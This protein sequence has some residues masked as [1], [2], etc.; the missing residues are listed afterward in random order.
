MAKIINILDIEPTKVSKDLQGKY[1]LIYGAAKA[2]KTTFATKMPKN[3]L[4]AFEQGYNALAGVKAVDI[5]KWA[6]FKLVLRQL[7][8]PEAQKMYSTITIDTAGIAYTM[9]EEYICAQQGVSSIGDIPYGGGYGLVEK[10]FQNCLRQI[11]Q[12]G[13][14]LIIISHAIPRV[15][16]KSDGSEIEIVSPDIPKRGYKVINQLVDIIGYIDVQWDEDGTSS[17]YLYTRKTP[18]IM[19][20]SRF[21]Y[22]EPKI[23]F[24]YDELTKAIERAIEKEAKENNTTLLEHHEEEEEVN[25]VS[26]FEIREEARALWDSLIEKDENNINKIQAIIQKIFG[27]PVRLSEI[28]ENQRDL[29]EL[30][31]T[32]MRDL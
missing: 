7:K 19:A 17:R 5:D 10:E 12:L 16:K 27:R 14:G 32:E 28:T 31:L 20:G 13:Y 8:S 26:F 2:G 18:R 21:K 30:V 11:T 29:F 22:L 6:T 9:C 1:I 25:E 4:C 23:P 15:E 3:L 24:G